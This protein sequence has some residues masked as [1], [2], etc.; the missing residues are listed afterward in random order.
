MDI[1]ALL[2]PPDLLS[3]RKALA[4]APHPD[5]V[6]VGMG[7]TVALLAERGVRIEYLTL[8][9]GAAGATDPA[10]AGEQLRAVRRA[11]LEAS[12]RLLG[13]EA[14]HYLDLPDAG[15]K[16]V[17]DL[18]ERIVTVI[19]RVRPDV[20]FSLDPWLPYEAHPD[21]RAAGFATTD[22]FLL[23]AFAHVQKADA[24]AGLFPYATPMMAY[25]GT[26][27]A[28]TKVAIDRQLDRKMAAILLHESQFS[29][30]QADFMK[31][32]TRA[33][34]SLCKETNTRVTLPQEPEHAAELLKVLSAMQM[35]YNTQAE[36]M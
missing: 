4:V 19:R 31:A 14:F 7:G 17:A 33:Q 9:D 6:E 34:A 35:H 22:A 3:A 28:N 8:T 21:H 27:R 30:A 5:D 12:G 2:Q 15:L 20:L 23:A 10:R 26:H 18:A 36:W 1:Q 29:G 13:V 11:E 24:D 16:Q 32:F 25:Y